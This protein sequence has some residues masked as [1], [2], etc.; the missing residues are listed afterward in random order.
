MQLQQLAAAF[1]V[2]KSK[3]NEAKSDEIYDGSPHDC[4]RRTMHYGSGSKAATAE[5]KEL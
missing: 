3:S 5:E 1:I 2:F 4:T